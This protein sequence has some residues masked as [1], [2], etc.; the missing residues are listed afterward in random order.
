MTNI[1]KLFKI[2]LPLLILLLVSCKGNTDR[3]WGVDNASSTTIQVRAVLVLGTD[4]IYESIEKGEARI[5]T[6]TNESWANSDP[7]Q[8]YDVFSAF[9]VTN[10][11]GDMLKKDFADNDNWEIYIEQ[12]KHRPDHFEQTYVMVVKDEDF[13]E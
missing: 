2:A 8:A 4:T 5:I 3:E 1:K 9:L 11:N 12:T 6:I 7:Q 13:E 10:A